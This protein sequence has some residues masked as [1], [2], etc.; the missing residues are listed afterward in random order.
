MT[1]RL[2]R[3][4]VLSILLYDRVSNAEMLRRLNKE[5]VAK[6][7]EKRKGI[8]CHVVRNEK[9]HLICIIIQNKFEE[10]CGPGWR[11]TTLWNLWNLCYLFELSATS[12]FKTSLDK[13]RTMLQIAIVLAGDGTWKMKIC[14]CSLLL[15]W[16]L[17]IT[18]FLSFIFSPKISAATE[19]I[20]FRMLIWWCRL[21]T[22]TWYIP[23]EHL[24]CWIRGARK[25]Q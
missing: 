16:L 5:Q 2:L 4:Y 13:T 15:K 7:I 12:L 18:S 11:R 21:G 9:F 3:R 14:L 25:R 20:S 6:F 10:K 1:F 24:W 17:W 22:A 23:T 8:Y 19:K